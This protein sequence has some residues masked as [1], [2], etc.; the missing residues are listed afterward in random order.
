MKKI[1]FVMAMVLAAAGLFAAEAKYSK[2]LANELLKSTDDSMYPQIFKS[3]MS[4]KTIRPGRKP[5]SYTYL[6]HSKGT[7]KALMEITSPARDKGKKILMTGNNLWMYVPAVSKPV[8]LSKKDSFMGSSFSN[9][10]LM[11][12]TMADDYE[13]VIKDNKGDLYLLEL[14]AKRPDVAY[15][16]IEIWVNRPLLVPTEA[17]YYGISGKLMKKMVFDKVGEMA[18]LKRPLH[19]KMEDILEKGAYTEV[20]FISMEE[21][22]S[23]PDYKFDQTQMSK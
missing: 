2:E 18:G 23:L 9:E 10:D 15:A 17:S 7:D 13:P 11:N 6:I 14:T 22:K 21:L 19:M 16:K 1:M 4:M 20:D 3:V 8:R 12:S 5:L